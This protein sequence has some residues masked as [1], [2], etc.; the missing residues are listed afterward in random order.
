MILENK[1]K[2]FGFILITTYF[3]FI[4]TLFL[5]S[6]SFFRNNF[7]YSLVSFIF[8]ALI[9]TFHILLG[10]GILLQY[11]W[12]YILSIIS[13]IAQFLYLLGFFTL[14]FSYYYGFILYIV[15]F[16][17]LICI[18]IYLSSHREYFGFIKNLQKENEIIHKQRIC[19]DCNREIPFDAEFCPY[20]G[21]KFI[22]YL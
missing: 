21:K 17:P 8:L 9:G 4:G 13:I 16:I 15:N 14:L 12:A 2:P 11:K 20:C 18:I 5:I 3:L 22:S 7:G 1:E 6:I 19:P 10:Y